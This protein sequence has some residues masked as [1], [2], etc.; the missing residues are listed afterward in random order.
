MPICDILMVVNEKNRV[1]ILFVKRNLIFSTFRLRADVGRL[2]TVWKGLHEDSLRTRRHFRHSLLNRKHRVAHRAWS[3]GRRNVMR[4]IMSKTWLFLF[5]ETHEIVHN[6]PR[7]WM[8]DRHGYSTNHY[9]ICWRIC[10]RFCFC[11]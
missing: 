9:T 11:R 10:N 1:L 8:L 4:D 5:R 7:L 6:K 3:N 2:S